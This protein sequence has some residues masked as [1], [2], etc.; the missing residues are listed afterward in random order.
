MART[1]KCGVYLIRCDPTGK[2]YIG[3]SYQ[4][5]TRWSQHRSALRRGDSNSTKLQHVWSKYG[6]DAFSFAILEEC[7][8]AVIAQKEQHFIDTLRPELNVLQD[9]TRRITGEHNEKLVAINRARCAAQT[10][11]KNGHE[12]TPENTY[13]G[14]IKGERR[15]KQCNTDRQLALRTDE[16]PQQYKIRRMKA[17]EFYQANKEKLQAQMKVYQMAHKEVKREYDR[18]RRESAKIQK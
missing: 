10:H 6:E 16:T 2:F 9:V 1:E 13:Y 8:R 11:C 14:K 5:Y 15:C 17:R 18:N 12:Y 3:S 4:I 7:E